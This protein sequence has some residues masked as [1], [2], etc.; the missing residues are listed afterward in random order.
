MSVFMVETY[1]VKPERQGQFRPLIK[2]FLKYKEENPEKFKE[3]KSWKL[4][5][6]VFGGISGAYIERWEF[7]N[8]AD[9]HGRQTRMSKDEGFMKVVGELRQESDLL[10]DPATR[11]N[12]LWRA[13]I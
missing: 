2:K 5:T 3:V 6:Q 13:I 9:M 12:H 8:M 10:I 11:S 7:D 4:F 1:L